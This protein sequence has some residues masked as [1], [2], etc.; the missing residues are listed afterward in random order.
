[1]ALATRSRI[2]RAARFVARELYLV[3]LC[4]AGA[5]LFLNHKVL[6]L[7]SRPLDPFPWEAYALSTALLYLFLR[8]IVLVAGLRVPSASGE[9]C[10]ECGR[11]LHDGAEKS[12]A[13]HRVP[14]RMSR[15]EADLRA[16][17]VLRHSVEEARR[18]TFPDTTGAA[19]RPRTANPALHVAA[20]F[21]RVFESARQSSRSTAH[22]GSAAEDMPGEVVNT[23]PSIVRAPPPAGVRRP[24]G[25]VRAARSASDDAPPQQAP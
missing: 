2:N 15:A 16:L 11:P 8:A 5:W 10:P 20:A 17:L 25:I 18:A 24:R 1:M 3:A 12:A 9:V 7:D 14:L 21:D 23:P 19:A 4:G 6:Y 13:S 22:D